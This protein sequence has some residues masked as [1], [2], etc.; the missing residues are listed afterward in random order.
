MRWMALAFAASLFACDPTPNFRTPE[1]PVAGKILAEE[2]VVTTGVDQQITLL[3][4]QSSGQYRIRVLVPARAYPVG[5]RVTIRLVS[6]LGPLNDVGYVMNDVVGQTVGSFTALQVLP[7]GLIPAVALRAE[8]SLV[9]YVGSDKPIDLLHAYEGDQGWTTAT[10]VDCSGKTVAF[11]L[12]R[13]GLWAMAPDLLPA[14]LRGLLQRTGVTCDNKIVANPLPV[15]LDL[16]NDAYVWTR[17]VS[18]Q[19]CRS[20]EAG[21]IGRLDNPYF[22]RLSMQVGLQVSTG[23]TG[24]TLTWMGDSLECGKTNYVSESYAPAP[25][26]SLDALPPVPANCPTADGGL[27]DVG[28]D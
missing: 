10:Q 15:L 12:N 18:A 8:L 3:Y 11:D 4:D 6:D 5:T 26:S 28:R 14:E 17:V 9:G 20:I 22:I 23:N 1:P 7:A 21:P 16:S 19:G 13:P 24:L 25:A 2:S 27:P